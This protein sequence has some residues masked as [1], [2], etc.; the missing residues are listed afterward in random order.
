MALTPDWL[1]LRID[2]VT[3]PEGTRDPA[4]LTTG[5]EIAASVRPFGVGPRLEW[6]SHISDRVR[7]DGA[8]LFRDEMVDG[9]FATW[10]HTHAFYAAGGRTVIRDRIE[11]ELPGGA[12]GRAVSPTARLGLAPMFRFRHRRTATLLEVDHDGSR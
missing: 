12:L 1:H 10:I 6:I 4:E 11:Y 5:T 3:G 7:Q 2:R 9:P 8:G